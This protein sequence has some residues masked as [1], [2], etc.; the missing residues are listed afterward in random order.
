MAELLAGSF[1][2]EFIFGWKGLG[3]LT[4]DALEKFDFPLVMGAVLVSALIFVVV[5]LV[6][7][8]VY[9]RLDPRVRL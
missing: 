2:V 6:A 4:V 1:F 9:A 8:L 7:D 3:K 5:S